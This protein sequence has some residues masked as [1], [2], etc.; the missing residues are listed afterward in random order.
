MF[1]HYFETIAGD[2]AIY[3]TISLAIFFLFFIGMGIWV[4]SVNKKY[5]AHMSSLPLEDSVKEN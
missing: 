3:P 5:I 1:K 4:F 2:I